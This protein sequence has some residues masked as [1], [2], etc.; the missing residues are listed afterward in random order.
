MSK[1]NF[2]DRNR[3]VTASLVRYGYSFDDIRAVLKEIEQ[4]M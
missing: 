2:D 4:E 3:K 1:L